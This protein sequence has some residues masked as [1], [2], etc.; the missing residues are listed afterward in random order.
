MISLRQFELLSLRRLIGW[1]LL[2]ADYGHVSFP[3][4]H[5]V[6]FF[7]VDLHTP[8][9]LDNL[10]IQHSRTASTNISSNLHN[11]EHCVMAEMPSLLHRSIDNS[12][13]ATHRCSPRKRLDHTKFLGRRVQPGRVITKA[14]RGRQAD[15]APYQLDGQDERPSNSPEPCSAYEYSFK[16]LSD[17]CREAVARRAAR[18]I[19]DGAL[20][21]E[22]E[23]DYTH[24]S[25]SDANDRGFD[26]I[27]PLQSFTVLAIAILLVFGCFYTL[28]EYL[29]AI[30]RV[31]AAC[32]PSTV[33]VPVTLTVSAPAYTTYLATTASVSTVTNIRTVTYTEQYTSFVHGVDPT[34]AISTASTGQATY[35][36]TVDPSGGTSWING[37]TPPSGVSRLTETMTVTI[38]P[39]SS[40]SAELT[41]TSTT[42]ATSTDTIMQTITVPPSSTTVIS[43]SRSTYTSTSTSTLFT[44]HYV[45]NASSV[46]TASSRLSFSGIGPGG[47]NS[48]MTG[49]SPDVL[50]CH[51]IR[52]G[53]HVYQSHLLGSW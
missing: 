1:H 16:A 11:N 19:P 21:H 39:Q 12:T 2:A 8:P 40:S 7:I 10:Q 48:T 45:N 44:T 51:C 36:Y 17:K 15:T 31:S 34:T 37:I 14:E 28:L 27:R 33:Y 46:T 29:L 6:P 52:P 50:Q 20:D 42:T 5:V 26:S 3:E 43:C 30:T 24:R 53:I 25:S 4:Q 38:T 47:W 9:S 18:L 13:S 22:E 32:T 41:T 23:P 35:M 49:P